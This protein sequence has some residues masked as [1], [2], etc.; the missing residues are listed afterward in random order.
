MNTHTQ[1][2]L[3]SGPSYCTGARATSRRILWPYARAFVCVCM[4]RR[5]LPPLPAQTKQRRDRGTSSSRACRTALSPR[6]RR[7]CRLVAPTQASRVPHINHS[8]ANIHTHTHTRRKASR[9]ARARVASAGQ[10]L[11]CSAQRLEECCKQTHTHT[12]RTRSACADDGHAC[13][14][15]CVCVL[16]DNIPVRRTVGQRECAGKGLERERA[17]SDFMCNRRR[18]RPGPSVAQSSRHHLLKSSPSCHASARR[19]RLSILFAHAYTRSFYVG[20]TARARRA[21]ER[22]EKF[23]SVC[24][25]VCPVDKWFMGAVWVWIGGRGPSGLHMTAA[26]PKCIACVVSTG[27]NSS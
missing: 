13:M 2:V 17:P 4:C 27:N 7:C 10:C 19:T 23:Y 5:L 25:C 9:R 21:N 1:V 3:P 22:V 11:R 12:T 8:L 20:C 18:R 24:V 6:H 15:V 16:C 14:R 26:L